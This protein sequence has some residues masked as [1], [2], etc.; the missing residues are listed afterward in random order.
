M[1][2]KYRHKSLNSSSDG[3]SSWVELIRGAVY[4][5]AQATGAR[6]LQTIDECARHTT[7]AIQVAAADALRILAANRQGLVAAFAQSVLDRQLE[8]IS[9]RC[10]ASGA[11]SEKVLCWQQF[12]GVLSHH[13]IDSHEM[14]FT[15]SFAQHMSWAARQYVIRVEYPD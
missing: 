12:E 11:S 14:W 13:L 6:Y 8:A 5:I 15:I 2:A 9:K 1:P 7:D 3:N 4:A 10:A